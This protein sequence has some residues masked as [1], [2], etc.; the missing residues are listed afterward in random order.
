MKQ[1]LCPY[2]LKALAEIE[3]TNG[4]HILP[5]A[6]GAPENFT[7]PSDE[8]ENARMN[9]LID[10]PA[11]NDPLMRLLATTQGVKSRSGFVNTKLEGTVASSGEKVA[12]TLGNGDIDFRFVKPVDLHEN[13][14]VKGVRGFGD[15]AEK[16]AKQI[17]ADNLKKGRHVAL[18]ESIAEP[19][20]HLSLGLEGDLK[21]IQKEVRKICYLM[22]VRV[23]GDDA[24]RSR[25]G[26]IYRAAIHVSTE[27]EIRATG[28]GGGTN[29]DAIP[30]IARAQRN[31]HALTC[32]RMGDKIISSVVLFGIISGF[33]ITP[34]EG[35]L[36]SE[37]EGEVV[38]IDAATSALTST[39][40]SNW[41][42]E[43]IQTSEFAQ[44]M[45]KVVSKQP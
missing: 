38:V 14:T 18:G 25:S 40:Y 11:I 17:V 39:L 45:A 44:A 41:F 2:S 28:L 7:I 27:E 13:G 12:V 34:A 35:F 6:F 26:A 31:Q 29:F 32:F 19:N 36:A 20:P 23:F 22:S 10:S 5:R 30:N 37:L 3:K 16:L 15:S 42:L 8:V 4:E 24:I 1:T 43:H 21:V 33:C 9:D